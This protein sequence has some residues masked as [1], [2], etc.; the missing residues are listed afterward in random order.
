MTTTTGMTITSN[1]NWV[2]VNPQTSSG[3]ASQTSSKRD[4]GA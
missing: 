2:K 4:A 3:W 1:A